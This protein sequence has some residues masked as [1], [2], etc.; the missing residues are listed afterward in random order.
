MKTSIKAYVATLW[1]NGASLEAAT[2]LVAEK[3]PHHC[4]GR[5]YIA[6]IYRKLKKESEKCPSKD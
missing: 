3:Y 6:Q 2:R 5:T 4:G 1:E